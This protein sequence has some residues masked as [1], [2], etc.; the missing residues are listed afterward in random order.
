MQASKDSVAA[1][2]DVGAVITGDNNTITVLP[3][4]QSASAPGHKT[5]VT[6]L[7]SEC[8]P[9]DLEVHYAIHV[10]AKEGE[11]PA[12]VK[13]EH[14][15]HLQRIVAA[16]QRGKSQLCV[17]VGES[18]T[19]K[20]RAAWEG[21][22]SLAADEWRLWHPFDPT[23]ADAALTGLEAVG[24]KTVVWL[25]E[26]QHYLAHPEVGEK[27]AAALR[28]LLADTHRAPILVLGTLWPV[29]WDHLTSL[30]I[31]P[32]EDPQEQSRQLLTG[33]Q[34]H[35]PDAFTE[36][37][38][39]AVRS[40]AQEDER[41]A[42]ALAGTA[43]RRITQFLAGVPALLDRYKLSRAGA[44]ALL[45]VAMDA[46]RLGCGIDLPA[47]FLEEAAMDYLSESELSS[48]DDD[49]FEQALTYTER[50]AHGNTALLRRTRRRPGS[51]GEE[52]FRLA[53]YME[54]H[55]R[56][57]RSR[58]CPPA[59]FWH[60]ALRHL[61]RRADVSALA[62]AASARW[63][64]RYALLLTERARQLPWAQSASSLGAR[65]QV[66]DGHDDS[67]S[68]PADHL[69]CRALAD[70]AFIAAQEADYEQAAALALEAAEC[71]QPDA[72]AD[73]ALQHEKAGLPVE[74][75]DLAHHAAAYGAPA[76]LS[77]LAMMREEADLFEQ[78]E[79]YARAAAE[80]GI[81]NTLADLAARREAAGDKEHAEELWEAAATYGHPEAL[82]SIARFR[83]ESGEIQEAARIAREALDQ[84]DAA[85]PYHN[86]D[87]I[88]R[89]LWPHG[90]EP[91]GTPTSYHH[92]DALPHNW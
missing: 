14:D 43:D 17:L 42:Q 39:V 77:R 36:R 83:Y 60:A 64:L 50:T 13:R 9:L 69:T 37:D 22:Q 52:S 20:T 54:Q 55:G 79:Y 68:W 33:R 57:E 49:W 87:P 30:P 26:A 32:G 70:L 5:L 53:D 29:H 40:A 4:A 58:I 62:S 47:A 35:V 24:P 80:Y 67:V 16:A 41:L 81:T 31:Q 51:Q 86:T 11:L 28:T 61:P 72:L 25:N 45:H 12:Y 6:R 74:A 84:G 90:I 88:W 7:I 85:Y 89:K 18:S 78:A 15:T 8:H 56:R 92:D 23:R 91:D 21:I 19:G 73:I 44:R 63:R 27:I 1:G 75:S 65:P 34:I 82:A 71:C 48:L 38:L 10:A 3:T 2:R 46:R 59:S 66:Y 76:C